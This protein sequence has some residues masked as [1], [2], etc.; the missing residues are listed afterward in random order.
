VEEKFHFLERKIRTNTKSIKKSTII[1]PE[2]GE[3]RENT[4]FVDR[5]YSSRG[6]I[7]QYNSDY[8]KMFL[9]KALP[10][11]FTLIDCGRFYILTQYL[12]KDNQLLGYKTD[13][14]RPLTIE[15]MSELFG[16]SEKQ[17]RL[18][19][20]RFKN[21]KIIKEV[22]INDTKWYAINPMYALKSKYLS[23]TTFLIFQEELIPNLPTWVVNKFMADVKEI[24]DKVEVKE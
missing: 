15:K 16:Q 9:N 4:A 14:I 19:I 2:T 5:L 3:Y 23:I 12:V 8:I 17:T 18:A 21:E 22:M 7:Y 11:Y 10:K 24:D 20:K 6:Y 13:K 1:N